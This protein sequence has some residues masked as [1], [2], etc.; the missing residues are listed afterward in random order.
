MKARTMRRIAVLLLG[1]AVVQGL[2]AT[3]VL[4]PRDNPPLRVVLARKLTMQALAANAADLQAKLAAGTLA[5]MAAN[6]R[7]MAS[8]ATYLPVVF[9]ETHAEVYP[10]QGDRYF[11]KGAPLEAVRSAAT[12]LNTAAE[13]LAAQAQAA[14]RAG[15]EAALPRLLGVCGACHGAARGQYQ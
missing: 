9:S 3:D 10:I 15:V 4:L 5:A 8:L 2:A 11:F 13:E 7:A 14:N 6:A 1:L 12:S